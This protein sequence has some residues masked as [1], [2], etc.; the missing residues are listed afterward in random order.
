MRNSENTMKL[1]ILLFA[2]IFSGINTF[3]QR[4]DI[5]IVRI[6]QYVD[7]LNSVEVSAKD[8]I[9]SQF[10]E[11]D[12]V[13]LAER[14]HQEETQYELINEVINDDYFVFKVGNICIEIGSANFSDSLNLFL[15]NFTGDLETGNSKLL[16]F[17]QSLSF[18]PVWNKKSYNLFLKN[19]LKLNQILDY[20]EKINL[21]LCD[22]E[23][24]W[25]EIKSKKDWE[26]AINN[27][28]DSIMAINISRVFNKIQGSPRKKMLVI[29]NEAHA[30]PNTDWVDMWQKRAAQYLTEKYGNKKIAVILINSV[31][32]NENEKDILIQDG[33]W[34][35]AFSISEKTNIGFD[36]KDSPFG[37]NKFDYAIGKN[38][39][40]FCYKDIF[41]GFVF[42]KPIDQHRLSTGVNG[43]IDSNFRNEFLRRIKIYNGEEYYEKLRKDNQLVGWNKI[44]YYKYDNLNEL[45]VEIEKMKQEYF[46]TKN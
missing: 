5:N 25:N 9:L 38:N 18:Y 8:Y 33:Y 37:Q 43:I 20:D 34:D 36:F 24:D 15:K 13:I 31:T 29:L 46:K 39:N 35:A 44:E 28:R 32:T 12:I 2:F 14:Y 27:N 7:F 19:I 6:D 21:H 3:S 17:Q 26:I 30:I 41:K 11:H 45:L 4:S 16:K 42:Y 1:I 23:F 10:E 40:S 22:R